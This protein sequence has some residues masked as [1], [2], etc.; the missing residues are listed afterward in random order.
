MTELY[1]AWDQYC[2][3]AINELEDGVYE[4]CETCFGLG[5]LPGYGACGNCNGSGLK[6]HE[7]EEE[8]YA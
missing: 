2:I 6:P 1:D 3:N 7:C 8:E 5:F 4:E